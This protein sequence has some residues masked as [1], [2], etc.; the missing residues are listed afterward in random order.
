MFNLKKLL[1][2][3]ILLSAPLQIK[4]V[5]SGFTDIETTKAFIAGSIGIISGSIRALTETIY[6]KESNHANYLDGFHDGMDYIVCLNL[7]I[8]IANKKNYKALIGSSF[9]LCKI[10]AYQLLRPGIT[11]QY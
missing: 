10:I 9:L 2:A 1:I 4:S 7:L 6:S 5:E 11:K 8:D 3:L